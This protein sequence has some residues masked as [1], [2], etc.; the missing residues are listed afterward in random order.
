MEDTREQGKKHNPR[1]IQ[2]QPDAQDGDHTPTIREAQIEAET[3]PDEADERREE[4]K[5]S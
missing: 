1:D 5:R 3:P 4:R 2:E